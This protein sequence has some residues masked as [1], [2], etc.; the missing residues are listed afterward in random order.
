MEENELN[1]FNR[2]SKFIF[3]T[4]VSGR[5]PP[6]SIILC[7]YQIEHQQLIERHERNRINNRS[8]L[9]NRIRI[10]K[11]FSAEKTDLLIVARDEKKLLEIKKEFEEKF[12]GNVMIYLSMLY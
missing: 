8:F 1:F 6:T 7:R 2:K 11:I 12:T 5:T 9:R 10:A 4:I 3:D